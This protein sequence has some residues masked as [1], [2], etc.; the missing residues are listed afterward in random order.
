MREKVKVA[1]KNKKETTHSLYLDSSNNTT[2]L[3]IK[4]FQNISE[5]TD[6]DPPI[7]KLLFDKNVLE[8]NSNIV[9]KNISIKDKLMT[10]DKI[11]EMYPNLKKDRDTIV[12]N[13]F[14]KKEQKVDTFVLEKV[15]FKDV[16]FYRDPD[17]NL[18]DVN[19]K[20]IGM[21]VETETDYIYYLFDDVINANK[22][23]MAFSKLLK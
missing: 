4:G 8:S 1:C 23:I 13:V 7:D 5:S 2:K 9:K 19:M 10:I 14:G 17:G 18:I 16:S 11:I 20:L 3:I 6:S 12:N 22:K 21:Y 15:S